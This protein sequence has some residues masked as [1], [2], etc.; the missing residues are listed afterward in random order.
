MNLQTIISYYLKGVPKD[1]YS[2]QVFEDAEGVQTLGWYFCSPA[3]DR[4]QPSSEEMGAMEADAVAW[5]TGN[6]L[7]TVSYY[8]FWELLSL[9]LQISVSN[10][11]ERLRRL[12]VPDTELALLIGKTSDISNQID[13][14]DPAVTG[15]GGYFEVILAKLV[16]NTVLTQVQAD[17]WAELQPVT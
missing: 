7:T 2:F 14:V 8:D 4:P 6:T 5:H 1:H 16:E 15:P 13:L 3:Y 11:A 12:V 9:S 17:A 10:E